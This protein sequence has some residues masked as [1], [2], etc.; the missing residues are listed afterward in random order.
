V[1]TGTA[2]EKILVKEDKFENK[3][4]NMSSKYPATISQEV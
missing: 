4:M 2:S 3:K 1:G